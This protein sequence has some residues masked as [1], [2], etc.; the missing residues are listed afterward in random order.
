MHFVILAIFLALMW[1]LIRPFKKLRPF[2]GQLL[3]ALAILWM[4]ILFYVISY[5]FPVPRFGGGVTEA[6][7]IPRVW[8]YALVPSVALVL[9]PIFRGK[10][11]PDPKW[12]N[13]KLVGI[14]L[15]SLVISIALFQYIGYYISSAIFI[16]V[17]MWVLGSRNKIELV[18]V[19]VGWVAFSY[20]IFARLLNVRLPVG[21]IIYSILN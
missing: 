21:S 16:V 6:G 18:A 8:F 15:T 10:D 3:V 19:P 12:G 9:I 7:T 14:V 13:I 1:L 17:C 11:E 2:T 4:G 20:F 5:S